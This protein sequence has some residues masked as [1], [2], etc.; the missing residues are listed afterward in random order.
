MYVPVVP[1]FYPK[2][3]PCLPTRA[4]PFLLL[5]FH[6]RH[7][8]EPK[9][10]PTGG[11][12][13]G[14]VSGSA[15]VDGRGHGGPSRQRR[16]DGRGHPRRRSRSKGSTKQRKAS[17]G[18]SCRDVKFSEDDLTGAG[19]LW[20]G[21]CLVGFGTTR[22][23]VC[24]RTNKER[25]RAHYGVGP[26]A[27]IAAI[28]DMRRK[29]KE[30]VEVK[31]LM[32]TL[33][34]LKLYETENVMAGR[35]GHCEQFCRE[36]VKRYASKLQRLK[37]LKIRLVGIPAD[38]TYWG[39]VDCLHAI[40]N[41]FRTDPGSKWYSHKHNGAGVSYEVVVDICESRVLWTAGPKP[42]STHDVTFFRGGKE[43]SSKKKKNEASWD[44]NALYFQIPKGKKLIGDSGYEGEPDKVSTS[45][46]EHE[47]EVKE[48]FARAKS[49][50]E[51]VNTRLKFFEVIGGRFRHGKGA[52]DKLKL[53]QMCFD[54][55]SVLVQYDME[56][57]HPLFEI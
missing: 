10:M 9:T 16:A 52:K 47:G 37:G 44:K 36:T 53:H 48:F 5:C 2:G 31:H 28:V 3:L 39:S 4:S 20:F 51:T 8:L 1:N 23:N 55:V 19:L 33:C 11:R 21:L 17:K 25:F 14:R 34:W 49:R 22:Q 13:Q 7:P 27:I 38:R 32:M 50:Q 15:R 46:A 41:E 29:F 56:N 57:G 6:N 42:A 30:E 24:D 12:S 26:L 40:M 43:E 45:I 18:G 35:W 54:A